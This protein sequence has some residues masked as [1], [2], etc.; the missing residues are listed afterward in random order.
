MRKYAVVRRVTRFF[1]IPPGV[2][3]QPPT[4]LRRL[5]VLCL[6]ML[7]FGPGVAALTIAAAVG[8][9]LGLAASAAITRFPEGM[10][11]VQSQ[12]RES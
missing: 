8:V 11:Y 3:R 1:L 12:T 4:P 7:A 5:P 9:T 10:K 2:R 6:A